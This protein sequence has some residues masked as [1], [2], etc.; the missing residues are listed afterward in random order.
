MRAGWTVAFVPVVLVAA[1]LVSGVDSAQGWATAD[2]AVYDDSL[3]AGWQDW[4][5]DAARDFSN[6]SP[7]HGGS[8]ASIAVTLDGWGGLQ[9]GYGG[10]Y[11]DVSAYD[12]LRFWIHGGSTGGQ[13]ID[14]FVTLRTGEIDLSISPAANTWTQVDVP[15]TGHTSPEVYSIQWFNDSSSTQPTFY[16]DDVAFVSSGAPTPTPPSPEIGPALHV[17]AAADRHPISPFIYG[18]NFA[19]EELADDL[20]LPVRRRGGNST[21]RYRWQIDVHNTGSDWY[22]ENIPGP[23]AYDPSLPDGS[24]ADLFVDQ[25]RATGTASILTVPL[26]GWTPK[27]GAAS[28][29]YDCG[30]KVSKYGP[31]DSVDELVN[32]LAIPPAIHIGFTQAQGTIP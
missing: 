6:A 19:D 10:T 9:V 22:Y 20:G 7:T 14:L 18:M 21:S 29:P 2:V 15:L 25:D 23:G 28:R 12:T 27:P 1:A 24:A 5:Y 3:A 26:L 8:S 17:D 30:F 32:S 31:Q 11:L 13:P 4:S 16:L